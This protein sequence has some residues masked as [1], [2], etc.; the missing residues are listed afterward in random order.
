MASPSEKMP[1]AVLFIICM[2]TLGHTQ[3]DCLEGRNARPL[4]HLG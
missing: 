4:L 3:E 2:A 1:G